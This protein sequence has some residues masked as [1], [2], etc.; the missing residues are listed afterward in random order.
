MA[1][2]WQSGLIAQLITGC[3]SS[4][5]KA[6][7]ARFCMGSVQQRVVSDKLDLLNIPRVPNSSMDAEKTISSVFRE[8]YYFSLANRKSNSTIVHH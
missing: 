8:Y 2:H 5:P 3:R 6:I 4:E 1:T 7:R